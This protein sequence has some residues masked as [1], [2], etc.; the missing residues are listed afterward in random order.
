[1]S[2]SLHE[3]QSE[4]RKSRITHST[5]DEL[6]SKYDYVMVFPMEGEAGALKQTDVCKHAVDV[7]TKAGLETFCYTSI[8]DD[9]LIVLVRCPVRF[10]PLYCPFYGPFMALLWPCYGPVMAANDPFKHSMIHTGPNDPFN[11]SVLN[12]HQTDPLNHSLPTDRQAQDLRRHDRLQAG[13]GPGSPEGRAGC[14]GG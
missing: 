6:S 7:M 1:M 4:T 9:E 13:A 10:M 12:R 3:R 11:H 14:G 8:Q 2:L 5:S